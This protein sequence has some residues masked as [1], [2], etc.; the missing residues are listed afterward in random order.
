MDNKEIS[1]ILARIDKAVTN[2]WNSPRSRLYIAATIA[3]ANRE[4]GKAATELEFEKAVNKKIQE[5]LKEV[6]VER[7]ASMELKLDENRKGFETDHRR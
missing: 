1:D 6:F 3:A 4:A 7:V 2:D 5:L